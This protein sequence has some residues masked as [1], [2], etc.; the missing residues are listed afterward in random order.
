MVI[1]MYFSQ[2]TGRPV[3]T[4]GGERVGAISDGVVRLVDGSFPQLTGVLFH[5][6]RR[7]VFVSASNLAALSDAGAKLTTPKLDVRAFERR[8]GEVLLARDVQGR[9]VID[10]ERG[11]LIRIQDIVL[12]GQDGTWQ[13][14][15]IVS[16]MSRTIRDIVRPWSRPS[17][18][19][20]EE[21]PWSR[22]EPLVGHV[23][24]ASRRLPLHRLSALRPADIADI[25]AHASHD[26]GEEIL[27]AVQADREL[28]ADVF[29]EMNIDK[30]IEYL[31]A[32]SNEEVAT[33]LSNMHPGDAVDLLMQLDRDRRNPILEALP[34]DKLAKIRVLLGYGEQTAG[35]LMSPEFLAVPEQETVRGVIDRIRTLPQDPYLLTTAYALD[36]ERLSG[37]ISLAALLRAAPTSTLR[38]VM[39]RDPIALYPQADIPSVAMEMAHYNLASLPIVDDNHRI[40]GVIT[41][42]DLIE[43]ILPN[44][45]RWRGRAER[46][47]HADIEPSEATVGE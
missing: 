5:L 17:G 40:V 34:A 4:Q 11:R 37:A 29:E 1:R 32:R 38:D 25:V 44:E 15:G 16:A 18:A 20:G 31:Q 35:G 26:E 3:L 46:A 19:R 14:I 6:G 33:V 21:I 22:I 36:G 45:W 7:D 27:N 10:V 2:L 41:F 39:E 47:V 23:P 28:E 9:A 43:A 12:E 42:D 13:V 30:Q 8:P 24:T